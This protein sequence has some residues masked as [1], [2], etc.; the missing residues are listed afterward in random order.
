MVQQRRLGVG[1]AP[2][3]FDA[4]RD[5]APVLVTIDAGGLCNVPIRKAPT[6]NGRSTRYCGCQSE[7]MPNM[8]LPFA[9]ANLAPTVMA[10]DRAVFE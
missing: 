5:A 6:N 1:L 8:R 7:A 3:A 2:R 9:V 10:L 4:D